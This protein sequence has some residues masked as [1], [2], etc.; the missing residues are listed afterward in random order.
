VSARLPTVGAD[1]GNWGEILNDFLEVSHDAQGNL[2]PSAVSSAL[3][4]PIPPTSL[5]GGTPSGSNFLRG[6][7][8]WA[9]PAGGGG[10]TLNTNDSDIQPLGSQAAG[11]TGKAADASHVH[12]MPTLNQVGIPTGSVS[13]NSQKITNLA[14]GTGTTD[15]AAFGQIPTSLPPN[16]NAGGDL[17]STYPNPI[18]SNTSNVASIISNNT[19]V[20]G[21]APLASPALTGT[22]TA[23]TATAGTNTTQI[24]TTAFATTAANAAQSAA[25][26]AAVLLSSLP[27]ATTSGGTGANYANLAALLTAL[28]AAG[29]GTMGGRLTAKVVTLTDS[30]SIALDASTGNMF[31]WALTGSTHT[32]AAPSNPV[33]GQT[34]SIDIKYS[35]AFTPLFNAAY[36]FGTAVPG[37]AATSGKTDTCAF[38]YNAT[39]NSGAGSWFYLGA[40]YGY[41][42]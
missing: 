35:G 42:S 11:S 4:T 5:G 22:P 37:W 29:G 30:A 15:A 32:L 27:L 39:A 3:P 8:T 26:A 25:E 10:V 33:D 36:D 24:A 34:I 9:V 13:L 38:R 31:R 40:G 20:T 16:G 19:T 7:G 6:D 12:A 21:K 28:L 41:T 18:L 17:T 1:Q 2:L 23:P 14:N